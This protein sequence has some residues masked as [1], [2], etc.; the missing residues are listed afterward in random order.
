MVQ[1][2]NRENQKLWFYTGSTLKGVWNR[3]I[4]KQHTQNFYPTFKFNSTLNVSGEE[5]VTFKY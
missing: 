2:D 4:A 5:T 3:S 1:E